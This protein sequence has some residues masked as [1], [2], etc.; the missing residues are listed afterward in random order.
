M[1]AVIGSQ[2]SL[3]LAQKMSRSGG[4]V[5]SA[6]FVGEDVDERRGLDEVEHEKIVTA[7]GCQITCSLAQPNPAQS[8]RD[9]Q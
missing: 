8:F 5:S 2:P 9:V 6:F 1:H 4:N 7:I 3:L